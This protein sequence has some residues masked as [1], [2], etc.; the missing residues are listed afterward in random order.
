MFFFGFYSTYLQNIAYIIPDEI[1]GLLK[2]NDQIRSN[3][4]RALSSVFEFYRTLRMSIYLKKKAN[5]S[6]FTLQIEINDFMV[7]HLKE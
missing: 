6:S 2:P 1:Y 3:V 7:E 4:Y 5:L